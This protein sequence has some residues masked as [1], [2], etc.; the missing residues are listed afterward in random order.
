MSNPNKY[1]PDGPQLSKF[2]YYSI[3][4]VAANKALTSKMIDVTP[5]EDASFIDGGIRSDKATIQTESV[6]SNG[7]AS[8]TSVQSSNAIQAKWLPF[9]DANRLTAPD[10]RIGER[11]VIYQF[12]ETDRFYWTTWENDHRLRK[13]ETIIYGISATRQE[14]TEDGHDNM[15]YFELSSHKKLVSFHT[16]Q[17]DGEPFGYDIQINTKDGRIVIVDTIGNEILIDSVQHHV[18]LK[19]S[20]ASIIEVIKT[21]C[22]V[23]TMDEINLKTTKMTVQAQEQI[24]TIDTV[25]TTSSDYSVESGSTEFSGGSFVVSSG[26]I[27]LG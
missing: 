3:G 11:V 6:D 23:S 17:A 20:D 16:S 26:Q 27:A 7:V 19:N 1:Q 14:D 21:I 4:V 8:S 18:R 22:N 15:Y 9:C 12:G 25:S 5:L 24:N 10:V 13:L 2:R